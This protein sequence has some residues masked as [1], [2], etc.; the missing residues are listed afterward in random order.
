MHPGKSGISGH[1]R[2]ICQIY[3]A[4]ARPLATQARRHE[5]QLTLGGGITYADTRPPACETCAHPRDRDSGGVD[6]VAS[7]TSLSGQ[8][9]AKILSDR[10]PESRI[11]GIRAVSHGQRNDMSDR[12]RRALRYEPL[13]S[14]GPTGPS[15]VA[16]AN[17]E[18]VR[19]TRPRRR[20]GSHVG[21]GASGDGR[22]PPQRR[23]HG[24]PA[25]PAEPAAGRCGRRGVRRSSPA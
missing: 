12:T 5:G 15:G 2:P 4:A 3:R 1:M 18:P 19:P 20:R 7:V 13:S 16:A 14:G 23:S 17:G 11:R 24:G 25:P 21:P 10:R 22:R 8:R 9:R 6:A